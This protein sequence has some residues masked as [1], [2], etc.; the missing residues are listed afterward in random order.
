M[1]LAASN[2][3]AATLERLLIAGLP[4]NSINEVLTP[5]GSVFRS[6]LR[7][8]LPSF[9]IASKQ[10]KGSPIIYAASRG[11]RAAVEVLLNWGANF[12]DIAEVSSLYLERAV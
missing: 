4:V 3:D 1:V 12:N 10:N 11:H 6:C 2:G 9:N 7:L 8:T 5:V